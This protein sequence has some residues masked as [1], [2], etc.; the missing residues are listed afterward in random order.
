LGGTAVQAYGTYREAD[1]KL[2]EMGVRVQ[3]CWSRVLSQLEVT[4]TLETSMRDGDKELQQR[5]LCILKSKLDVA[6][7]KM[8][9]FSKNTPGMSIK[10]KLRLVLLKDSLDETIQELESWQKLYE[11]FWF[12]MIKLAPPAADAALNRVI[13]TGSTGAAQA[14]WAARH[15]RRAFKEPDVGSQ[16][17]FIREEELGSFTQAPIPFCTARVVTSTA[18]SAAQSK[19]LIIEIVTDGAI[20]S[21]DA[22]EF[23]RRLRQSDPLTSGLLSCKGVIRYTTATS[24]AF[25]FRMPDGYWAP[26]SLRGLLLSGASHN[27]LSDRLEMAKQLA[28][29]VYYVHLYGFVHKN[30][31][32]ETVV[33]LAKGGTD[34]KCLPRT[35]FLVGFQVIRNA[36]GKTYPIP[37][38]KRWD[39]NLYRHPLRQGSNMESFVMQHDI[40]SL[41]VC[42]LE[43]GL[44][45][46]FIEYG[47]D[48]T[49]QPTSALAAGED[50]ATLLKA[51][52]ALKEHLAALSR[53]RNLTA[54]LG[55]KYSKVVETCLTCLDDDNPDFEHEQEF[56]DED[57]LPVG[58]RYIEKVLG[59]LNGITI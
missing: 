28:K 3:V 22:R 12:H 7:Q 29:A 10:M 55:T 34:A 23:A 38:A 49:A 14:G 16:S 6:V 52:V 45:E 35:A 4:K 58:V 25:L 5:V 32:P 11:P 21:K 31:S 47:P 15:F 8:A 59:I 20:Q 17:V 24:L 43:L 40:Y 30:I 57:G 54:R 39:L 13:K 53:S 51:P 36:D 50:L 9:R 56:Q 27:S 48:G 18:V 19:Q 46:S 26:R 1:S 44:W 37:N 41:G 2:Y 42:L 33:S